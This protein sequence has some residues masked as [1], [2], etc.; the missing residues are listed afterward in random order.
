M[1]G[2]SPSIRGTPMSVTVLLSRLDSE[3]HREK[4]EWLLVLINKFLDDFDHTI[5][6]NSKFSFVLHMKI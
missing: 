2:V 5:Y 3:I 6:R 1:T 4:V